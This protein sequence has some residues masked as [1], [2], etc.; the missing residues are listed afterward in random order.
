MSQ[1]SFV[2]SL[3]QPKKRWA[4]FLCIKL[5][6]AAKKDGL[7]YRHWDEES[8]QSFPVGDTDITGGRAI[9]C[10]PVF[11]IVQQSQLL[12][13]ALSLPQEGWYLRDGRTVNICL[14]LKRTD[15]S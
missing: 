4:G 14:Y 2:L 6:A 15:Q 1:S 9:L 11:V 5:A 8:V 13:L 7:G 10:R 12:V 3:L